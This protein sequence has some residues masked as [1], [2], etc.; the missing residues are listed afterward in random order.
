MAK[1]KVMKVFV[2][3]EY[4][5]HQLPSRATITKDVKRIR[6]QV[7]MYGKI[8]QFHAY[9]PKWRLFPRESLKQLRVALSRRG[10]MPRSLS[11]D[12]KKKKESV[13]LDN[14]IWGSCVKSRPQGVA[15]VVVSDRDFS[16]LQTKV[17]A[18]GS[19]LLILPNPGCTKGGNSLSKVP[20]NLTSSGGPNGSAVSKADSS[21][22]SVLLFWDYGRCPI[23]PVGKKR[24]ERAVLRV[25]SCLKSYI[26]ATLGNIA[27]LHAY[28]SADNTPTLR[29]SLHAAGVELHTVQTG[30]KNIVSTHIIADVT[31]L[32]KSQSSTRAIVLVAPNGQYSG[33][34]KH[35]LEQGLDVVRIPL[36]P[37]EPNWREA[38][39]VHH[40]SSAV[41]N[42][43]SGPSTPLSQGNDLP[44]EVS[45]DSPDAYDSEAVAESD[46]EE[47]SVTEYSDSSS[48][49]DLPVNSEEHSHT[50]DALQL[51]E[52][53]STVSV[54]WD[55]GN[56]ERTRD[57]GAETVKRIKSFAGEF[58]DITDFCAYFTS[59]GGAPGF[60]SKQMGSLDVDLRR[61]EYNGIG[62]AV[63]HQIMVDVAYC[64][65]QNRSAKTIVLISEDK[66]FKVLT[67]RILQEGVD[68]VCISKIP[69]AGTQATAVVYLA[70]DYKLSLELEDAVEGGL[71]T[72]EWSP[73]EGGSDRETSV[74]GTWKLCHE[75]DGP[76]AFIFWDFA[77][78]PV[79][80]EHRKD[81][82]MPA[83]VQRIKMFASSFGFVRS[84]RAYD[85]GC[86][87]CNQ[88][89]DIAI[90]LKEA[91]VDLCRVRPFT[92]AIDTIDEIMD[93]IL[94]LANT[95][96][97]APKDTIILISKS[98]GPRISAL[99]ERL[100]Q[101]GFEFVRIS[102]APT[103]ERAEGTAVIYRAPEFHGS[104]Y[105]SEATS[106]VE[107]YSEEIWEVEAG[108]RGPLAP[109]NSPDDTDSEQSSRHSA[110]SPVDFAPLSISSKM[111]SEDESIAEASVQA[112]D[113]ED[114]TLFLPASSD[115][116]ILNEWPLDFG[117]LQVSGSTSLLGEAAIH[118][119]RVVRKLNAG[120]EA[121]EEYDGVAESV[122]EF[123]DLDDW[124][125]CTNLGT[126]A[127]GNVIGTDTPLSRESSPNSDDMDTTQEVSGWSCLVTTRKRKQPTVDEVTVR[128]L[129]DMSRLRLRKRKKT[130]F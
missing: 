49:F 115:F 86:Q 92:G 108:E 91:G 28:I 21:A 70:K 105:G 47:S 72:G 100:L 35:L 125:E 94:G 78:S 121:E 13:I 55:Y 95:R 66:D 85:I 48:D 111:D 51:T 64:I 34:I 110:D 65:S 90:D 99:A 107:A 25:T 122:L 40:P 44:L 68:V 19:S 7:A 23:P 118:P 79:P 126:P 103:E 26:V 41:G 30:V 104:L 80:Y 18:L 42:R 5:V 11:I 81:G 88:I 33:L 113:I 46:D 57:G 89:D 101:D 114:I 4:D 87:P 130:I 6:E 61:V 10:V 97:S 37:L 128:P 58:G 1:S 53:R 14:K 8:M 102:E 56:I 124:E 43:P 29:D 123:S 117:E 96:Q 15:I 109:A 83:G 16:A 31:A 32:V 112:A 22:S 50:E 106:N 52:P 120:W 93:D 63:D 73:V 127:K 74:P 67:S 116:D 27:H 24:R 17:S 60:L 20:K 2:H 71:M 36:L 76:A 69:V 84:F 59:T 3:W 12:S 75:A 39:I 38:A 45:V 77:D 82:R 98:N 54:Y 129:I 62:D 119:P 9:V